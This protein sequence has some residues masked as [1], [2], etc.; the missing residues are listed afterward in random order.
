ML[1]SDPPQVGEG[2]GVSDLGHGTHA[3]MWVERQGFG[4]ALGLSV[5]LT[6][7]R[8]ISC[9]SESCNKSLVVLVVE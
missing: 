5:Y 2:D 9:R 4:L 3:A 1:L 8:C 6:I 7:F